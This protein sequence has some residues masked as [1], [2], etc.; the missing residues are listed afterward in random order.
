LESLESKERNPRYLAITGIA[1]AGLF[2]I[3]YRIFIFYMCFML[4]YF[5]YQ[6]LAGETKK[7]RLIEPAFR[8]LLIS[9]LAILLTLPWLWNILTNFVPRHL[10]VH[11]LASD[12][13]F[14]DPLVRQYFGFSIELTFL[15]FNGYLIALS[16]LGCV[17][18][19]LKREKPIILIALWLVALFIVANLYLSKLPL[20][21]LVD[22]GAVIVGLYLPGS[23]L[24][25]YFLDRSIDAFLLRMRPRWS[26]SGR[27]IVAISIVLAA[28]LGARR[29]LTIIDPSFALVSESDMLAMDWIRR[30]IPEEAKFFSNSSLYLPDAIIGSDAGLWIPLLTGREATVP[31]MIYNNDGSPEYIAAVNALAKG[32]AALS[33]AGEML[34][35]LKSHDVTHIYIGKRGGDIKPQKFINSPNYR[36][37]YQH[38][39][40]WIFEI[41][42]E[43]RAEE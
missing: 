6:A 31:P 28:L 7:G 21:G 43:M 15:S 29:M 17:W 5:L 18:G 2:L 20:S 11:S 33:D 40:V 37:I 12:D 3:H 22:N 24:S 32:I 16:L 38:D 36:L 34:P 39:G 9:L 23:M 14:S 8:M 13:I 42:Y 41:D 10:Q 30:N 26:A 35:L 19:V 27:A 25:G 4:V 1:L